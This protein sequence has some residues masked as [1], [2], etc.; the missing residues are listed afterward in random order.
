MPLHRVEQTTTDEIP[1][2]HNQNVHV[3]LQT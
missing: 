1:V 2:H 3:A